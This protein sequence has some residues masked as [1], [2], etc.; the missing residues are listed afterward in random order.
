MKVPTILM[1]LYI[2]PFLPGRL[3]RTTIEAA[4]RKFSLCGAQRF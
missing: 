2:H 1:H 4:L 3:P